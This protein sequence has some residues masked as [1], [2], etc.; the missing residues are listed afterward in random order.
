[1]IAL[2]R[3]CSN[4]LHDVAWREEPTASAL[5]TRWCSAWPDWH[6][7]VQPGKVD[8]PFLPT[9]HSS[10]QYC[11]LCCQIIVKIG[12]EINIEGSQAGV[13]DPVDRQAWRSNLGRANAV[14]RVWFAVKIAKCSLG[15]SPFQV[16]LGCNA[17]YL[18]SAGDGKPDSVLLRVLNP[19]VPYGILYEEST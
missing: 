5:E 2:L 7:A 15:V 11:C 16:D 10:C 9:A 17:G 13:K 14:G 12:G 18:L 1:M 3:L 6:S 4:A 8:F 19:K